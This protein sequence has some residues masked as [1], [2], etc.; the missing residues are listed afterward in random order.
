MITNYKLYEK[1][2]NKDET[3]ELFLKWFNKYESNQSIYK[4]IPEESSIQTEIKQYIR[5][6]VFLYKHYTE[7]LSWHNYFDY[8]DRYIDNDIDISKSMFKKYI[9][10]YIGDLIV[11]EWDKDIQIFLDIEKLNI[12]EYY[13]R[14]YTMN[15]QKKMIASFLYNLMKKRPPKKVVLKRKY[16]I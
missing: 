2:V 11:L 7:Y 9:K 14:N 8:N 12:I 13:K 10:Q 5:M 16:K 6:L 1:K 3:I 15:Q 4:W